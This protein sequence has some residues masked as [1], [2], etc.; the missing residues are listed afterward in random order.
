MYKYIK[1]NRIKVLVVPLIFYWII[2]FVGTS[3]PADHSINIFGIGDKIKHFTAYLGLSFLLGL[4]LYFQEKSE[5][6]SVHYLL[7]TFIICTSYG[8]FDELHQILV[9]NR[10]AEFYD[11]FADLLGSILGTLAVYLIIGFLKKTIRL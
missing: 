2:L 10:S 9:P 8:V 7:Y 1:A 11:W 5:N 3:L 4:N 6:L